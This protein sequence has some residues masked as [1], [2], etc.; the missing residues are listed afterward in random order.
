MSG[1]SVM[2]LAAIVLLAGCNDDQFVAPEPVVPAPTVYSGSGDIAATVAEF[3]A[4]LGSSNGGTPGE[5]PTGRREITWDGAVA[6]PFNN[7]NDFPADFFN[8][9][10]KSGAVFRTIGTGLRNDSTLFAEINPT[11]ATQFSFFSAN[12]IFAP[13]GSNQLEQVFQ[14]AGEQTAAVTRAFG[15][16]L[17]DVD[18]ADR[19]TIELFAEDGSLLGRYAAPV[20][21]D[22]AGLSFIGVVYP[23]AVIDRVRI[24]LGT[25]AMGPDVND[26][27]AGGTVDLVALDNVI[28]GEPTRRCDRCGSGTPRS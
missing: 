16:V 25:G 19:T 27:S 10:V 9:N 18:L 23:D 8:R 3:R 15:I 7:K 6:R 2:T 20:R 13:I 26:V 14:I 12:E 22:A 11:Y 5:Q 28:F 4:A 17:S 24:T 1:M 21:S